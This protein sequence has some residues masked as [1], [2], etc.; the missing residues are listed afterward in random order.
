[1]VIAKV[2]RD[3]SLSVHVDVL[4]LLLVLCGQVW[5]TGLAGG[6]GSQV[7]VL[8]VC[9]E[10]LVDGLKGFTCKHDWLSFD[11]KLGFRREVLLHQQ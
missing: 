9:T 2:A 8:V 11:I 5:L 6:L 7:V 3:L 4:C 1:M 10:N